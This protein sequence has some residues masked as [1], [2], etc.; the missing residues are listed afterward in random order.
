MVVDRPGCAIETTGMHCAVWVSIEKTGGGDGARRARELGTANTGRLRPV[1]G[2]TAKGCGEDPR[3]THRFRRPA[4][5]P[6]PLRAALASLVA[7][8]DESRAN[9]A[10]DPVRPPMRSAGN[11][12]GALARSSRSAAT[13]RGPGPPPRGQYPAGRRRL[14]RDDGWVTK[15]FGAATTSSAPRTSIVGGNCW[16]RTGTVEARFG[17]RRRGGRHFGGPVSAEGDWVVRAMPVSAG[18]V[19]DASPSGMNCRSRIDR[20]SGHGTG[21]RRSPPRTSQKGLVKVTPHLISA[22]RGNA[23][24]RRSEPCRAF[25][26]LSTSVSSTHRSSGQFDAERPGQPAQ[27]S[28]QQCKIVRDPCRCCRAWLSPRHGFRPQGA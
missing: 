9:P 20:W 3:Q 15:H 27:A 25:A 23:A 12:S 6:A 13:N 7:T 16:R 1:V 19:P 21:R 28:R 14:V 8:L 26:G 4:I 17:L 5:R 11:S 10:T 2:E 24:V 18:Q 22:C